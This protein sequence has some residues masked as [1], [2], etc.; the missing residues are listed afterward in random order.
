VIRLA[1]ALNI[2]EE[3]LDWALDR[4]AEVLGDRSGRRTRVA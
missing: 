3:L 1:P 2:P 4:V